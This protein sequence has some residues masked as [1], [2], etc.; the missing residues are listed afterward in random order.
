MAHVRKDS[1]RPTT[2]ISFN[3]D[4]L[5]MV[6]DYRFETRKDN[7]SQ[8]IEEIIKYG[9]KYLELLEK[10]RNKQKVAVN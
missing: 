6:E 5:K 9:F 7:R 3:P 10:K 1:S 4:L 2:T 8:A